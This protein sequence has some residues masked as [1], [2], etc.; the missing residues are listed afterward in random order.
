M[1]IINFK[2]V[3]MILTLFMKNIIRFKEK[4]LKQNSGMIK[5]VI[6]INFFVAWISW[7]RN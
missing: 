4:D 2:V 1:N 7:N 6:Y 3:N 5:S